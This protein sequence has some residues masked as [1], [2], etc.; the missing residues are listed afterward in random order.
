MRRITILIAFMLCVSTNIFIRKD[1]SLDPKSSELDENNIYK[2]TEKSKNYF[3][4]ETQ[5]I[6]EGQ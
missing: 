6:T 4:L 1:H 3:G 2:I 5:R